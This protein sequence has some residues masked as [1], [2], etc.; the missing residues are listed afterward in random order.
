MTQHDLNSA[1]SLMDSG[2]CLWVGAGV[3]VQIAGSPKDAPQWNELTSELEV[4]TE[5][6]HRPEWDY[7]TRLNECAERLG[8]RPFQAFL[9]K[10]YYT[11]LSLV[12]LKQAQKALQSNDLIP[13]SIR[14][15]ACLGQ[16]A[17][18][19][20]NFNIEPLSSIL[21]GRP[22]GPMRVLSYVDPHKPV[23]SHDE[24][25]ARFRR[26]I[27]HP[28]GLA[29][30]SAVMTKSQYKALGNSLAF[31]LAVHAAFGSN[32]A[33]VGMSLED[34]YLR[35]HLSSF[36][37]DIGSIFWFNSEFPKAPAEWAKENDV[38]MVPVTWREFWNWWL[39]DRRHEIDEAGLCAAWY[40]TL[41]EASDEAL[42]GAVTQLAS[43]LAAVGIDN[44]SLLKTAEA[45]GEVGKPI[46]PEAAELSKVVD[47][48][49]AR[50][51]EKGFDLPHIGTQFG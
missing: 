46:S 27:Y 1:A 41:S 35:D 50:I 34:D 21:L 33:I 11:N 13:L 14:Q 20:V 15:V 47:E 32:L 8:D 51:G 12:L 4:I 31:A 48:L 37:K 5:L 45:L 22:A 39:R 25:A 28:H 44:T 16:I 10:R 23:F 18:P 17:N 29:T 36:R 38:E 42:G 26:L 43:S 3:T 2:C 30:G 7:P 6:P 40:R 9:R 24:A 49:R 19:I